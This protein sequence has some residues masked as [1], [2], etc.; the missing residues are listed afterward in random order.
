MSTYF[1]IRFHFSRNSL[2]SSTLDLEDDLIPTAP[3]IDASLLEIIPLRVYE[4]RTNQIL[5]AKGTLKKK[6]STD[7]QFFLHEHEETVSDVDS[8]SLVSEEDFGGIKGHIK[9][10]HMTI[11]S[12]RGKKHFIACSRMLMAMHFRYSLLDR[13]S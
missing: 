10:G 1:H 7:L 13:T 5:N 8:V 3:P 2:A 11:R 9:N 12:H 6:Q 4:S